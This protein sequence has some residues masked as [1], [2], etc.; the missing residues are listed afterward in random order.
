MTLKRKILTLIDNQPEYYKDVV[1]FFKKE[2]PKKPNKPKKILQEYISDGYVS[3]HQSLKLT[4]EGR[5][6][7]LEMEM[8][9]IEDKR[10]WITTA[11]SVFAVIVSIISIIVSFL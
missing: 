1:D 10:F 9:V 11:L 6:V 2:Y 8:R 4:K 7:L 3:D 5:H